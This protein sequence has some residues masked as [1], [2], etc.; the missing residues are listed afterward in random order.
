MM[1]LNKRRL[2]EDGVLRMLLL[3]LAAAL[4]YDSEYRTF[5]AWRTLEPGTN[6]RQADTQFGHGAA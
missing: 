1:I 5:A 6:L 3:T 2:S 4:A